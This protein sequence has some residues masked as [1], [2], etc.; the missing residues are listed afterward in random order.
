[1]PSIQK[2]SKSSGLSPRS[3]TELV[4]FSCKS[5]TLAKGTQR[6][7]AIIWKENSSAARIMAKFQPPQDY[8]VSNGGKHI[9]GWDGREHPEIRVLSVSI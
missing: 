6:A 9:P 1:M 7:S 3:S 8:T 2:D 4:E 5:W